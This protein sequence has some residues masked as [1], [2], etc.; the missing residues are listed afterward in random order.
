VSFD[1]LVLGAT[2][3]VYIIFDFDFSAEI[4]LKVRPGLFSA[5]RVRGSRPPPNAT[6]NHP[7]D[8]IYNFFAD[9]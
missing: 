9:L 8:D 2:V 3:P 6:V 4:K 5:H 1:V 7:H